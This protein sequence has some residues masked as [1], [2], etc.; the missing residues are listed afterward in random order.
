MDIVEIMSFRQED[1]MYP[2]CL[3]LTESGQCY[4]CKAD[5]NMQPT[6]QWK[7]VNIDERAIQFVH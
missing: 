4:Y 7:L 1:D 5:E 2:Y 3:A 6:G